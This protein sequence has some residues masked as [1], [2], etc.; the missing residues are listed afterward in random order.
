ML[1][2]DPVSTVDLVNESECPLPASEGDTLPVLCDKM[3]TKHAVVNWG[4]QPLFHNKT[5][6]AV[7]ET[8]DETHVR[9]N[10]D[11]VSCIM[12]EGERHRG[13]GGPAEILRSSIFILLLHNVKV[14]PSGPQPWFGFGWLP[15]SNTTWITWEF[16]GSL[17]IRQTQ[18]YMHSVHWHVSTLFKAS[19]I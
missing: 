18:I 6:K 15:L 7:E 9:T 1:P 5:W 14:Q 10:G 17:K 3:T 12:W 16:V 4:R 19:S 13:T 2:L 11:P 8:S